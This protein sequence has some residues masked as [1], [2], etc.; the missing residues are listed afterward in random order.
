MRQ[1]RG[2][3]DLIQ[4]QLVKKLAGRTQSSTAE[5]WVQVLGGWMDQRDTRRRNINTKFKSGYVTAECCRTEITASSSTAS[6]QQQHANMHRQRSRNP[7]TRR[8]GHPCLSYASIGAGH[9]AWSNFPDTRVRAC[10]LPKAQNGW[11]C[12]ITAT[13]LVCRVYFQSLLT[14]CKEETVQINLK[15]WATHTH[16]RPNVD[17]TWMQMKTKFVPVHFLWWSQTDS[18]S[19]NRV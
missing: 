11:M 7:N 9:Q 12:I 3:A 4:T 10:G 14:F 19:R 18:L 15:R 17:T 8:R 6:H 2:D 1:R 13:K 5:S 16:T